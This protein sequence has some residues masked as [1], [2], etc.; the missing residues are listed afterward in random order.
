MTSD[1][2]SN[3]M[4]LDGSSNSAMPLSRTYTQVPHKTLNKK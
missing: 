2:A 3:R 4:P 1:E